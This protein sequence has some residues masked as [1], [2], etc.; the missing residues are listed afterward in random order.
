M[1]RR[2]LQAGAV[3]FDLEVGHGLALRLAHRPKLPT[4]RVCV[5]RRFWGEFV[6]SP[7]WHAACNTRSAGFEINSR[8]VGAP[9][10]LISIAG[11]L[12]RVFPETVLAES[13]YPLHRPALENRYAGVAP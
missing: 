4:G 12:A 8:F 3:V 5:K 1:Q 7:A 9:F 6:R 10:M 2:G 13:R 11:R